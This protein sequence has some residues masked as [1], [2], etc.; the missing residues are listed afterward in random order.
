M[1]T[2]S[3]TLAVRFEALSVCAPISFGQDR[4]KHAKKEEEGSRDDALQV[5]EKILNEQEER[6]RKKEAQHYT[7]NAGCRPLVS[8]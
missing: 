4:T 6:V 3:G 8:Q 7:Y 2:T 5:L 1:V